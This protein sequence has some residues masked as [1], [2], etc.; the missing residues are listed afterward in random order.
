MGNAYQQSRPLSGPMP[1]RCC[2]RWDI[3]HPMPR[4]RKTFSDELVKGFET[5]GPETMQSNKNRIHE[6]IIQAGIKAWAQKA[7]YEQHSTPLTPTPAYMNAKSWSASTCRKNHRTF[8]RALS[9]FLSDQI[10]C[11][12]ALSSFRLFYEWASPIGA[13]CSTNWNAFSKI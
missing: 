6:G 8:T 3:T 10:R 11:T 1:M 5:V 4:L 13:P 2:A 7:D 12:F 9:F